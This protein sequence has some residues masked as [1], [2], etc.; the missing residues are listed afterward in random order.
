MLQARITKQIVIL[1]KAGI[2]A[3]LTSGPAVQGIPFAFALH[4][5]G[6]SFF[7]RIGRMDSRFRGNDD[8]SE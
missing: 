7:R 5:D 1:A 4:H 3:M 8:F 2:H 6:H